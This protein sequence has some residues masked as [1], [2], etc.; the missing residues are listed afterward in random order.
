VRGT[1]VAQFFHFFARFEKAN[2]RLQAG[3]YVFDLGPRS[4]V[5]S[6]LHD[7]WVH[8]ILLDGFLSG[9]VAK[10][11]RGGGGAQGGGAAQQATSTCTWIHV[12]E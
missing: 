1:I 2:C 11:G 5:Q 9:S 6:Q 7:F 10:C 3:A 4:T 12:H 8:V